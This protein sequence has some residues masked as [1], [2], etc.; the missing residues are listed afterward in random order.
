MTAI[1]DLPVTWPK[2]SIPHGTTTGAFQRCRRRPE[3]ACEPCKRAQAEYIKN[4]RISTGQTSST[5]IPNYLLAAL[6]LDAAPDIQAYMRRE[7]SDGTV[8]ALLRLL[9]D[10]DQA[11]VA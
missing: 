11:D 5:N 2:S 7:L 8:D 6:I 10:E 9:Y 4:W 1:S 3:G